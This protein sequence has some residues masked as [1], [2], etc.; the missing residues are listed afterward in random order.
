MKEKSRIFILPAALLQHLELHLL[1]GLDSRIEGKRILCN[2]ICIDSNVF[3]TASVQK[4]KM[5][6]VLV[7]TS[8][9]LAEQMRHCY[10][11]AESGRIPFA[12]LPE[13]FVVHIR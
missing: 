7:E 11:N 8:S 12:V 2:G 10:L 5:L 1:F 3:H 6:M 9:E 13:K 4:G